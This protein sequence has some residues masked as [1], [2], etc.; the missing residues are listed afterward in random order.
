MSKIYQPVKG[1]DGIWTVEVETGVTVKALDDFLRQYDPPLALPSNVVLTSVRYGG[2][3]ATGC[4]GAATHTRTLPDLVTQ[5][6]IVDSNGTLNTFTK[7]KDQVEFS[8]ATVNLGLMGIIYSYTIKIE[9]MFNLKMTDT[10]PLYTDIF[11]DPVAGGAKL[12]TMVLSN[13]Q[14]EIFYWPFNTPLLGALND[15]LWVK[16]WQRSNLTA[17]DNSVKD[18]LGDALQSLEA[19]LGS[20][21]YEFMAANPSSTPY[22]VPIMYQAVVA[23]DSVVLHAPNAIHYQAGIDDMPC[24]D[25]EMAFKVDDGFQNVVKAWKYV[26]DQVYTYANA[27]KYP[28]NL[29]MEM[30]FVKSSTMLMSPAYDEDP[31]AIYCMIEI[32]SVV[33]TEGFDDFS[34]MIAKY[35]MDNFQAKPHWAKMWEHV[36]GIVPY[37]RQNSGARYDKFDAVRQKY[38]PNGMFMTG[39][40]AGVL[41]H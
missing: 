36:P 31:N 2:V 30:R 12:K 7:D 41:G 28:L 32:L 40:F 19:T 39:T 5:V 38:D 23:D 3:L 25:L 24:L 17:T 35:W 1:A 14:T 27:G 11:A 22:I 8:A 15:H 10:H 20:K 21:A 29:L 16:Q 6:K 34:A 33:N 9:P 26:V 37:L 4:H 18:T 13:D